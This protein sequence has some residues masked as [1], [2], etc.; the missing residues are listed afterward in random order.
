MRDGLC[1]AGVEAEISADAVAVDG[2]F[3]LLLHSGDG[4]IDLL[5][6]IEGPVRHLV[7]GGGEEVQAAGGVEALGGGGLVLGG[8]GMLHGGGAGRMRQGKDA[9]QRSKLLKE[10]RRMWRMLR[11]VGCLRRLVAGRMRGCE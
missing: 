2:E 9:G 8:G 11:G 4:A 10:C 6:E 1:V 5:G 3:D 7:D